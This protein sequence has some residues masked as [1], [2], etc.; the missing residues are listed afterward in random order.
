MYVLIVA[1]GSWRQKGQKF[2]LRKFEASLHETLSKTIK[3][4]K[5]RNNKS[6]RQPT[7][8]EEIY[9]IRKFCLEYKNLYV[10]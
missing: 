9:Q 8:R 7:I 5:E 6:K 4:K 3:R 2:K 1:P 10:G